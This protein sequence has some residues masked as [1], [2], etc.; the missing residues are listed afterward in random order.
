MQQ[1]IDSFLQTI[2]LELHGHRK[3]VCFF[4]DSI[5]AM[6]QSTGGGAEKVTV[7]EVGCSNGVTVAMP[8]AKI[9][10]SVKGIDLHQ[11]SVDAANA[12]AVDLPAVFECVLL[13]DLGEQELFD[14]VILSD[15]LE[16]VPDPHQLCSQAAA[17]L[18][19]NGILLI[20]IPN[21]FGLYEIE[22]FIVK[23]SGIG[24]LMS[25]LRSILRRRER[26]LFDHAYNHDSPHIQFFSRPAIA[27]V[28]AAGG[29]DVT[30]AQNG[31]LLGGDVTMATLGR[32]RAIVELTLRLANMLPAWAVSTWYFECCADGKSR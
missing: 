8:L 21:G 5:E 14:V 13:E 30:R 19:P 32:S 17:R 9:G 16:H 12:A 7:L 1:H 2:P 10:Y 3:K 6:R 15:V 4:V 23:W 31:C 27:R 29:L 25:M 18:K 26:G 20:S 11:P 24:I 22:K 28:I